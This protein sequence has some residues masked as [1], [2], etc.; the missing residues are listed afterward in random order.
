MPEVTYTSWDK[1]HF[2]NAAGR[3]INSGDKDQWNGML[4]L[5]RTF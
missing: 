2:T 4:R 5:E 1:T 3:V